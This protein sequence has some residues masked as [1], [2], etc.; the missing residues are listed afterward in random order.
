VQPGGL[1]C[2]RQCVQDAKRVYDP[3]ALDV[4]LLP[5]GKPPGKQAPH[6]ACFALLMQ[7]SAKM[8][9]QKANCTL[10]PIV[11]GAALALSETKH[12]P[13]IESAVLSPSAQAH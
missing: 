13:A 4:N 7:Y 1:M 6:N 10:R 11:R 12:A 2:L 8:E 3:F 9:L 5:I